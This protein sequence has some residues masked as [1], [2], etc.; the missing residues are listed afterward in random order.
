MQAN[1]HPNYGR[2]RSPVRVVKRLKL[3]LQK[4]KSELKSVPS[5][6]HSILAK[7]KARPIRVDV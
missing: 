6:T 5:V 7:G 3:G 1:I 4:R 2:V